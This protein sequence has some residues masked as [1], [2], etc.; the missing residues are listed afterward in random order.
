M[1]LLETVNTFLRN[2]LA[3]IVNSPKPPVINPLATPLRSQRLP[4]L[5]LLTKKIPTVSSGSSP[6]ETVVVLSQSSKTEVMAS[7]RRRIAWTST[8]KIV[9][10]ST[11]T[12]RGIMSAVEIQEG[13]E[14]QNVA[15]IAM[16]C[17]L[18]IHAAEGS[19]DALPPRRLSVFF[20][21]KSPRMNLS[22][23]DHRKLLQKLQLEF[24]IMTCSSIF[25]FRFI[26]A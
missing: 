25:D 18:A 8:M 26:L 19:G 5:I 13:P 16:T 9:V 7:K 15:S 3:M 21:C 6:T 10:G 23:R 20:R 14:N 2:L 1:S 4:A 12:A 17:I 24:K 11:A 22:C